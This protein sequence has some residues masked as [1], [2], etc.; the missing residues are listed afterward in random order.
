MS[1]DGSQVSTDIV[2]HYTV[3]GYEHARLTRRAGL[4]ERARTQQIIQ[5]Y[6]P[7]SG[8]ESGVI[9]DIGG[10]AGIYALWLAKLGYTVHLID[11]V[12]LHVEQALQSSAQQPEFP[13]ASATVGDAR[14][15]QV[16]DACADV[17]LLL[18]PLYHLTERA[19][20]VQTLREAYRILKPGG[21]VIAAAISQF[22]SLM[23]GLLHDMLKDPAFVEIVK[24]D[25]QDGQHRNPTH[26]PHY[27]TTAFFHH[28]DALKAEAEAAG[29]AV[30]GP[31]G[32]EGPGWFAPNFDDYVNDPDLWARLLDLMA[33]IETEPTL[34]GVSAHLLVAGRKP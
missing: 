13:L 19:D 12:P 24:R 5:R 34:L 21:V 32:V 33:R 14:Q 15:L 18:G 9:W 26:H 30:D 8:P 3:G 25:L 7:E 28:P 4:L 31:F 1:D 16:D 6:L 23:D 2:E 22:A 11:A 27:F 20:R 29:F 10:G 17:V